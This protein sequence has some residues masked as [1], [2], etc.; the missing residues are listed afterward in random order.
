MPEPSPTPL[1]AARSRFLAT[2]P[3]RREALARL[4]EQLAEI[5]EDKVLVLRLQDQ[6]HSL[7]ASAIAFEEVLLSQRIKLA[8]DGLDKR[9]PDAV[10]QAALDAV[11]QSLEHLASD[12]FGRASKVVA[13]AASAPPA[14]AS[15]DRTSSGTIDRTV[16]R[17]IEVVNTVSGLVAAPDAALGPTKITV[18]DDEEVVHSVEEALP[19]THYEVSGASDAG[20]ALRLMHATRPSLVLVSVE[21]ARDPSLDLVRRIR[22]DPVTDVRQILLLGRQVTSEEAAQLGADGAVRRPVDGQA[23]CAMLDDLV[24]QPAWDGGLWNM[25]EG[26]VDDIAERVAEEIRKGLTDS[27]Q[28]GSDE[29]IDLS[30]NRE[31]VAAAWSAIGRIRAELGERS[32]GRLRFRSPSE[33]PASAPPEAAI[34]GRR[35]SQA[36]DAVHADVIRGRRI[37]VADDDPAVL[38]FFSGLLRDAG[39]TVFEAKNGRD[40]LRLSRSR[41]PHVVI[42]D[43]LMPKLDGFGLCR[44]LSRDV[45]LARVPVVL[46]SWKQDYLERMRELGVG[47]AGYLRKEAGASQILKTVGEVLRPRA[48]LEA[49]LEGGR[50]VSGRLEAIGVV[51]MIEAVA[52]RRPDARIFVNDA[53]NLFEVAL[54]AGQE[55]GVTRTTTDGLFARGEGP[56][57]QLLGVTQGRFR[58]EHAD[59]EAQPWMAGPLDAVVQRAAEA[60]E[61]TLAA[62]SS[63]NLLQIERV[64][65]DG[66]AVPGFLAATP[67][68]LGAVLLRVRDGVGHVQEWLTDPDIGPEETQRQLE[69]LARRGLI[70]GV[71]DLA[72][73]NLIEAEHEARL[74]E[75][76]AAVRLSERAPKAAHGESE[77]PEWY[78]KTAPEDGAAQAGDGLLL[79][80]PTADTAEVLPTAQ[81]VPPIQL[82]AGPSAPVPAST[83]GGAGEAFEVELPSDI[84]GPLVPGEGPAEASARYEVPAEDDRPDDPL[85]SALHGD[86]GDLSV[87]GDVAARQSGSRMGSTLEVSALEEIGSILEAAPSEQPSGIL[88]LQVQEA[89]AVEAPVSHVAPSQQERSAPAEPLS[90]PR[91]SWPP[92]LEDEE[93]GVWAEEGLGSH[94]LVLLMAALMAA[95]GYFGFALVTERPVPW[96]GDSWLSDSG[97]NAGSALPNAAAQAKGVLDVEGP[98]AEPTGRAS[99]SGQKSAQTAQPVGIGFGRDQAG[100]PPAFREHVGPDQGLLQVEAP[101]D[102][103]GTELWVDDRRIGPAP[104]SLALSEGRHALAFRQGPGRRYRFVVIQ[105]GRTLVVP[106]P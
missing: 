2:L 105:A 63:R 39:A 35:Q 49:Q 47:A 100:I 7:S 86:G 43:I 75:P 34:H 69:E 97:L 67:A 38:W 82:R 23:L 4:T 44:A 57:R 51:P 1:G 27:L 30:D 24:Q 81:T 3:E 31:L 52:V 102:G 28:V 90:V 104:L 12:G 20:H 93:P 77:M 79:P 29:R 84:D 76:T 92:H 9:A 33:A 13:P 25:T 32:S 5:P 16:D 41:R 56:L 74:S 65:V 61:S 53:W 54:R 95:V 91:S 37:V 85:E 58:I 62:V 8:L 89:D 18:I 22:R 98:L 46:L 59:G 19:D 42:S 17:P 55:I 14:G 11:C 83:A 73:R 26:T 70:T 103:M 68:P 101:Q 96:L 99:E 48:L 60:L 45:V 71:Y 64:E 80:E 15:T 106:V 72:G 87:G 78:T 6:L 94:L 36:A 66:D 88:S 40:A 21:L 10:P 50:A